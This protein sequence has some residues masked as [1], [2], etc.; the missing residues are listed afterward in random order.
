[1]KNGK[2]KVI[3]HYFVRILRCRENV[4]IS[5]KWAADVDANRVGSS[6]TMVD[7]FAM[8]LLFFGGG[9]DDGS[10]L[11]VCWDACCKL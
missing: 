4:F 8:L 3:T 7:Y 6:A 2:K 10:P 11:A 9:D 5:S 1:M